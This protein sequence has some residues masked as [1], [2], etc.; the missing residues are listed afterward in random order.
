[1][2]RPFMPLYILALGGTVTEVGV[3]FTVNTASAALLR[4][5]GG[6]FSDAAGRLQAV[7][8]GTV[9]GLAGFIGYALSPSWEWLLISA[10][11][12]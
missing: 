3:F 11:T 4:P 7:G 9:F 8:I 10:I 12:L 6:W 2:F 1:M 5:V